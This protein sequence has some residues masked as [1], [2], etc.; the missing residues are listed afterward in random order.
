[1][2]FIKLLLEKKYALPYR[3]LDAVVAHFMRFVNK[4][5]ITPVIWHQSLLTFVQRGLGMIEDI[6][7][8]IE[9]CRSSKLCNIA[10]RRVSLSIGGMV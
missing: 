4:T 7:L 3:V 8:C 5:R 10:I 6:F 1:S 9:W 2:Y